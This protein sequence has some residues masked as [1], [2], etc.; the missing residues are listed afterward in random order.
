MSG[1]TPAKDAELLIMYKNHDRMKVMAARFGCS[2]TTCSKRLQRLLNP[3]IYKS[4]MDHSK[5]AAEP[6]KPLPLRRCL[7]SNCRRWFQP[8]HAGQY[9][10][11]QCKPT[12]SAT[13][14]SARLPAGKPF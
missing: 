1:W 12:E 10:H 11:P 4:S 2:I 9:L 6:K 8:T 13:I 7:K 3:D 14:F 5:P